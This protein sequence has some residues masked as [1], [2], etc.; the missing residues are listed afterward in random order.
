MERLTA[1]DRMSL[2]PDE[3]GWPEDIGA[4]AVLDG[5]RLLD[6]DDRL[7][8]DTVRESI[9]SAL[10][11][12]G[13]FVRE[14]SITLHAKP[15]PGAISGRHFRHGRKAFASACAGV[16]KKRQFSRLGVRTRQIGRQ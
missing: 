5:A 14:A 2:A 8:I 4:L 6:G 16:A 13:R 9:A 15:G 10:R 11:S 3:L 7:R 12:Q 1:Q